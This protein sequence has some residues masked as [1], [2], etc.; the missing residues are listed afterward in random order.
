MGHTRRPLVPPPQAFEGSRKNGLSF[1]FLKF[2]HFYPKV[3]ENNCFFVK[4]NAKKNCNFHF[5][6]KVF[7]FEI[8]DF[9]HHIL[10]RE[11]EKTVKKKCQKKSNFRKKKKKQF[12]FFLHCFAFS[13]VKM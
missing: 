10:N 6:E 1:T 2:F 11:N 8:F 5:L 3:K 9:L 4:Q 12:D 7:H 13:R